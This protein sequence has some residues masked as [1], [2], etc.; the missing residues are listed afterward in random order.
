MGILQ[1]DKVRK[2]LIDELKLQQAVDNIPAVINNTIQPALSIN[3]PERT[4]IYK[5]VNGSAT[6]YT[7]PLTK[8]FYLTSLHINGGNNAGGPLTTD[9]IEFTDFDNIAHAYPSFCGSDAIGGGIVTSERSI[10]F[11]NGLKLSRNSQINSAGS[12]SAGSNFEITGFIK[13]VM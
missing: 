5:Q 7:T 11:P 13:E 6:L 12:S 9:Q 1:N 2:V 4:E 8:D 10:Y 3:D